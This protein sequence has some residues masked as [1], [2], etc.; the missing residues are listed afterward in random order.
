VVWT[1]GNFPLRLFLRFSSLAYQLQC[2]AHHFGNC[3]PTTSA[4][5]WILP[6][7]LEFLSS[8]GN[9]LELTTQYVSDPRQRMHS[10]GQETACV[11]RIRRFIIV[12]E[13]TYHIVFRATLKEITYQFLSSRFILILYFHLQPDYRVISLIFE[14]LQ[15]KTHISP[16]CKR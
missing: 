10:F 6:F 13:C 3:F 14:N 12:L 16:L 2:V 9:Y 15:S 5:E 8:P 4:T 11:C 7:G 1:L